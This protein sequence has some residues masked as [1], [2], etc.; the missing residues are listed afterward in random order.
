M[1]NFNGLPGGTAGYST[2]VI[3]NVIPYV[4]AHYNVSTSPDDRALAGLSAGGARAND[5]LVN[6]TSEFAYYS[7]M[8]P[9]G[10][11][12]ATITSAQAAAMRSVLS[13]QIGGGLQDPIRANLTTQESELTAAGVP[14]TDDSINGGHEW[15]VWRTLLRDFLTQMAF[16]ATTTTITVSGTDA[17]AT[18][19]ADTTE[20]ATPRGT[21]QFYV[22]GTA[23]G[24]PVNVANGSATVSL[25]GL[26]SGSHAVTAAYSGDDSYAGS[27]GAPVTVS[28]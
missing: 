8:S 25:R 15:Y 4:E 11:F 16:N 5:L 18:V 21:V 9:G 17:V 24:R 13:L 12:P 2:D 19:K 26:A 28:G 22:D 27:T 3:N 20:P 7:I 14:F 23:F 1:T 6:H 10:G